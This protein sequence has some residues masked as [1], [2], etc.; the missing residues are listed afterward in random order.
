MYFSDKQEEWKG[1]SSIEGEEMRF[2][3]FPFIDRKDSENPSF[4]MAVVS[5]LDGYPIVTNFQK[6]LHPIADLLEVIS[7]GQTSTEEKD[8]VLGLAVIFNFKE[9]QESKYGCPSSFL[10]YRF[11]FTKVVSLI[12]RFFLAT[13]L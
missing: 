13:S 6:I 12:P 10:D 8:A 1:S 11:S 9:I 2:K 3:Y 4:E 5:V 7:Y